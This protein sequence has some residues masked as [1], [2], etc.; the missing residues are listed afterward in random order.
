M[1]ILDITMHYELGSHPTPVRDTGYLNVYIDIYM[2]IRVGG[3]KK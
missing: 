2:Y 1:E 3:P